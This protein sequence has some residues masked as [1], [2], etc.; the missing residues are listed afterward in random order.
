MH[1]FLRM[2]GRFGQQ[3]PELVYGAT[4]MGDPRPDPFQR[5]PQPRVAVADDEPR[6]PQVPRHQV[7]WHSFPGCARLGARH[8]QG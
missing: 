4:L 3:V 2:L 1:G 8:G 5:A 6:S 7:F